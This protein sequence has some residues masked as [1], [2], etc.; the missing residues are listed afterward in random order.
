[1]FSVLMPVYHKDNPVYFRAALASLVPQLAYVNEIVLVK[2]GPL[3]L[4]LETALDAQ[5]ALLPLKVVALPQNAGLANALNAG[6]EHC[7]SAWVFRFDADDLC[8]P[9]PAALQSERIRAAPLDIP[10]GQIEECE[11]ATLAVT[12]RRLVP[13]EAAQIRVFLR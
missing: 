3:G 12:G 7:R 1:M 2:D 11:P 10:G 9:Q 6:L 13:C 5:R 4:A 8:L